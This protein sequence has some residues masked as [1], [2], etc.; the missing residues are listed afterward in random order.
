MSVIVGICG[1]IS[2]GKGTAADY[3]VDNYNFK[4][5]SFAN[6]VKD[7]VSVIFNWDRDLLEG[8][9]PES[10]LWRETP[11]AYWSNMMEREFSPRYALQLMG[12]ESGRNVFHQNL[13]VY[14]TFNR[15]IPGNRYVL[16]DVRF[17]N[18]IMEIKK[19]GG[20]VIRIKKGPEPV[21]YTAAEEDNIHSTNNMETHFSQIH[22][23]E[24][25]WIGQEFDYVIENNGT[26]E[27]FEGKLEKLVPFLGI[28]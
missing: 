23:S 20:S 1:F 22:Y 4:K 13:W 24:W 17:P 11:D 3:L 6:S 21:W 15:M 9:T 26:L 2:S 28:V 7:A 19:N 5:E 10:R 12:T 8:Q 27:E 25:A 18:E 14:S 16:A